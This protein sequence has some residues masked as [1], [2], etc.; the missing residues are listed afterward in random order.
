M[1]II[2]ESM[3]EKMKIKSLCESWKDRLAAVAKVNEN[4]TY[5]KKIA[6]A[7]CLEQTQEYLNWR[8]TES[9]ATQSSDIGQFK[10]FALDVLTVAV[11]NLI[12]FDLVSVQPISN[13]NGMINYIEYTYNSNKGTTVEGDVFT[14]AFNKHQSNPSFTLAAVNGE[15]QPKATAAAVSGKLS[16]K[17]VTPGSVTIKVGSVVITDDGAGVL[18]GTGLAS[19]GTINYTTGEYNFTL[20]T[21]DTTN[22]PVVNYSYNNEYVPAEDVPQIGIQ[23]KS[24][25]VVAKSRHLGVRFAYEAQYELRKEYDFD[26]NNEIAKMA[27]GELNHEIDIEICNDLFRSAQEDTELSWSKSAPVGVT[28]VDHYDSFAIKLSEGSVKVYEKTQRVQP[29]W[30]L[31]GT[32]VLPV[33]TAMRSFKSSGASSINGPYFAGTLNGLKVYVNPSFVGSDANAFLLGYKGNSLFEAGYVYAPYMPIMSSELLTTM[34]MMGQ[35]GFV[36]MYAT[37]LVNPNLYI[38]GKVTA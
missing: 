11:P 3:V 38:K 30:L 14:D 13:R 15:V 10:R 27:A 16:W 1:G 17:P 25:P 2:S 24:L 36:T 29:N 6:L 32:Q 7:K 4:F 19:D 21:A 20:S 26:I 35:R 22:A 9:K 5:E 12:A 8:L 37:K 18:K 34:D 23:L 28:L 31:I 33:V